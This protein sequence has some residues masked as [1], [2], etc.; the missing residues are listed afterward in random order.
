MKVLMYPSNLTIKS[1]A[2]AAEFLRCIKPGNSI[3]IC[4]VNFPNRYHVFTRTQNGTLYYGTALYGKDP[5]LAEPL[6]MRDIREH[7]IRKTAY[8][9][10]KSINAH[11]HPKE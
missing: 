4:D 11:L 9:L 7:D 3:E 10:R 1:I 5:F 2:S 6:L 8:R